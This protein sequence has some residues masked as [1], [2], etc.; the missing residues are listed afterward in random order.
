MPGTNALILLR[1][2]TS[3]KGTQE[4]IRCQITGERL[5]F[6]RLN[7]EIHLKKITCCE[8]M[9]SN[10]NIHHSALLIGT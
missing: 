9:A 6:T 4:F 1:P 5:H 10:E 2:N 8:V 7:Q 3:K